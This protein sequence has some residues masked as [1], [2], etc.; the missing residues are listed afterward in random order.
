MLSFDLPIKKGIILIYD[1]YI[2]VA[3]ILIKKITKK[4]LY[5]MFAGEVNLKHFLDLAK[6]I[7]IDHTACDSCVFYFLDHEKQN[8]N[9]EA[10]SLQGDLS[11]LEKSILGYHIDF[12]RSI[13]DAE[14]IHSNSTITL[15]KED[16]HRYDD[17][18]TTVFDAWS[19]KQMIIIPLTFNDEVIGSFQ[20]IS[21]ENDFS[22][23]QINKIKKDISSITPYLYSCYKYEIFVRLKDA[24]DESGD[25][26]QR[27]ISLINRLG[28]IN[29]HQEL[30]KI[31]LFELISHYGFHF[32]GVF[33][34]E[35]GYLIPK[36][37]NT[38]APNYDAQISKLKI[39]A[40][41]NLCSLASNNGAMS[42]C[43][44]NDSLIYIPDICEL[45]SLPMAEHDRNALNQIEGIKSTV[46]IPLRQKEKAIGVVWL[47]SINKPAILNYSDKV[48]LEAV[49][50]YLG[51]AMENTRMYEEIE[52]QKQQIEE[53][54]SRLNKKVIKLQQIATHDYLTGLY[55]FGHFQSV[56]GNMLQEN[57]RRNRQYESICLVMADIDHFKGF[58]DTYGHEAGNIALKQVAKIISDLA[59][60]ADVVCRYG[61]EEFIVI[62]PDCVIDGAVQFAERVRKKIEDTSVIIDKKR[63][64]I[65]ISLGCS[66]C[67][68]TC[69]PRV[70]ISQADAKLY[71]SKENGRNRVEY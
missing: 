35:K 7:I 37:W 54:N 16:I 44:E 26:H 70:C 23:A 31:I 59:R 13:P 65:T 45:R 28:G 12:K 30:F 22:T 42:S 9:I 29:C 43:F 1:Y 60:G 5:D 17:Y 57:N 48:M 50:S 64:N 2:F 34:N 27:V 40:D 55:N 52:S 41:N 61:G 21:H 58:N 24:L 32:G 25:K 68:S 36:H 67:D 56:L 4:Y 38:L 69:N 20:A 15:N 3:D 63:V 47:G 49:A 10:I 71:D 39:W 6:K 11:V 46:F 18:I 33:T 19:I 51:I 66:V 53:L 14:A 8:L 62:L